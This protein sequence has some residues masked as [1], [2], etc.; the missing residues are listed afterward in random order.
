M[1]V[2]GKNGP[3]FEDVP[4]A[5][6]IAHWFIEEMRGEPN[7]GGDAWWLSR[8]PHSGCRMLAFVDYDEQEFHLLEINTEDSTDLLWVTSGMD[9]EGWEWWQ[10]PKPS[11]EVDAAWRCDGIIWMSKRIELHLEYAHKHGGREGLSD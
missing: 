6:D 5:S 11:I 8:S 7:V 10:N 1:K 4:T 2:W 3:V 9:G